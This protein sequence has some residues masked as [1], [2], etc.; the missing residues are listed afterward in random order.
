ML[1]ETTQEAAHEAAQG[2]Q[3]AAHAVE[4]GF[5]PGKTI[6]DHILD[7][8]RFEIMHGVGFDLPQLPTVAG[9]DPQNISP[10][11]YRPDERAGGGLPHRA[12]SDGRRRG[13]RT[14]GNKRG[15]RLW[16]HQLLGVRDPLQDQ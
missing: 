4:T 5:N 15:G 9:P 2:A 12:L 8:D 7:H 11:Q 10:Q 6:I 3:E 14:D 1:T 16:D 13:E